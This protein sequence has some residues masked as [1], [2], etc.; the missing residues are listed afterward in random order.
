[1]EKMVKNKNMSLISGAILLLI[2]WY[3]M[4]LARYY[5]RDFYALI[6]GFILCVFCA[7][8]SK[9]CSRYLLSSSLI[10]LLLSWIIS[11][12]AYDFTLQPL[13]A[14]FIHLLLFF[15]FPYSIIGSDSSPRTPDRRSGRGTPCTCTW[16]PGFCERRMGSSR[17][18]WP[19]VPARS[20]PPQRFS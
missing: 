12:V 20:D 6:Y 13:Y 4:P 10:A 5:I 9:E 15:S 3:I 14:L 16:S 17:C 1:M 8:E 19:P 11:V 18:S 2:V 7:F